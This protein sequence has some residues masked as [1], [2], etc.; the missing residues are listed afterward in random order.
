MEDV[1]LMRRVKK[2]GG[3]IVI[4]PDRVQTSARRW[5]KEGIVY[6][7]LRNWTLVTL[8]LLGVP[9]ERLVRFYR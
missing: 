2:T 8:Y 6:A 1:D 5:Q 9:P 3:R 4:L 7:T